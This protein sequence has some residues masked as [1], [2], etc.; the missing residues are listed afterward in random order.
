MST[1]FSIDRIPQFFMNKRSRL[2]ANV[3]ASDS[4]GKV[5]FA[6]SSFGNRKKSEV[7]TIIA[8]ETNPLQEKKLCKGMRNLYEHIRAREELFKTLT[9]ILMG[10]DMAA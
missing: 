2:K 1:L 5:T 6:V 9:A 3:K 4:V 7:T 10:N 8:T